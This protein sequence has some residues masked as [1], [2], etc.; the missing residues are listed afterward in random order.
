MKEFYLN[1]LQKVD[2]GLQLQGMASTH[3]L[4]LIIQINTVFTKMYAL[5]NRMY[6]I[7]IET[8]LCS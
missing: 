6:A 1:T 4:P 3:L 7:E 5:D 2:Q 8:L